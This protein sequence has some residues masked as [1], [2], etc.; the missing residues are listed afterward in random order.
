MSSFIRLVQNEQMKIYSRLRT[1][2]MLAIVVLSVISAGVLMRFV[3][4]A[5]IHHTLQF[6]SLTTSLASIITIFTVIIAGDIVASEFT[7]GT[8]KLLLIRPASRGKILCA[9]YISVLLFIL[10][11]VA[12][13]LIISY[14]TGLIIFGVSGVVSPDMAFPA[15]LKAYGLK[16]VQIVMTA[17]L[18]FMIS[19]AFR[20]SSLAIGLSIFLMLSANSIVLVLVSLKKTWVKYFLFANTDL[21]PYVFGGKPI[22]PGMTLGFSLTVLAAYWLLF[23]GVSWLLFTKRDVAGG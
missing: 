6:M 18:A 4:D 7:W 3:I 19:A 2:V 16:L 8:I 1:W 14:F 9:K 15:I 23:Y 11:L 21:S 22:L 12:T 17:T 20:S 10:T 13:M 5:G